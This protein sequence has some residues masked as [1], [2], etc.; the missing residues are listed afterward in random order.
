MSYKRLC[1]SCLD[2]RQEVSRSNFIKHIDSKQCRKNQYKTNTTHNCKFCLFN[3]NRL[4]SHEP[5]CNLNPNKTSHK[6]SNQFLKARELGTEF[7]V[8]NVT[9]Q[10]ISAGN[11]GKTHSDET[12]I[13][14]SLAMQNA[15]LSNP[16]SY[17]GGYNRGRV[18]S[19][20]CSNGFRVL[21][22]WERQ[23]V[24]FCV[25]NDVK[26]EQPNTGFPYM[27]N[28]PRVYFP[29]FYLPEI[30][31]WVEIKGLETERDRVKWD[32]LRTIHNKD[33]LVIKS[34][35]SISIE[36]LLANTTW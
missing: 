5:Y 32:A 21:G 30:D 14:I 25:S 4:A 23:F 27:W 11:L 34:I 17:A 28:G 33:L 6:T 31:K 16:E 15:V 35:S 19:I 26:I 18:K 8:S 10:R 36:L 12:K 29:D 22:N 7:V 9:R 3:F 1:A 2:C 20:V 24:E 13:K